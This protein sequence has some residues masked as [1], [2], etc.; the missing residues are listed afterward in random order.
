M[1][2]AGYA[3]MGNAGRI[4]VNAQEKTTLVERGPYRVIR[5]PINAF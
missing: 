2:V 4:G 1:V 3:A 5:H